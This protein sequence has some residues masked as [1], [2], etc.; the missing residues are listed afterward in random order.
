VDTCGREILA[1]LALRVQRRPATELEL[2]ALMGFVDFASSEGDD[3]EAGI[4][5]ALQAMLVSPQFLYRGI[6][7][8]GSTP[9]AAGSITKLDDY[10]LASRLSYF[11]W[12]STPDSALLQSAAAGTLSD[13]SALRSEFDRLLSDAKSA[14]LY[15]GFVNQ[16]LS[17][18][19]LQSATP[20]PTAF[21]QFDETLRG[22]MA[23]EV[24]LFFADLQARD[25]SALELISGTSSFANDTL[26]ALY[27]VPAP[28]GSALQPVALDPAQRAGVLTMPAV[29]TMTSGPEQPNIVRR[30]V[31]LMENILCAEPPPPPNGVPPAPDAM[32][33][34]SERERL[35]RHRQDPSCASCHNLIDPLGFA[36]E[37]YD[38]L[39][40]WRD[41]VAGAAVDN[42]GTLPDGRSFAGIVE[43]SGLLQESGEFGSCL[44]EKMASYALGRPISSGEHCLM[45]AIGEQTVTPQS[46]LSDLLWAI[47]TSDAFLLRETPE[48][49]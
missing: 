2:D 15:D 28:G 3:F 48:E 5:Y 32:A 25:G 40:A 11:L 27:G 45:D 39:G 26:A 17:L 36:F 29:L 16:W 20:D 22:Q 12:G 37:N 8:E 44:S 23:E 42:Q 33:G 43:L 9:P 35:A 38:A 19:K 4:G 21:P 6:P 14:A 7:A 49:P 31:W 47:T 41:T 30:G 18:G 24:R 34:E 10:A 46:K 1:A 13:G